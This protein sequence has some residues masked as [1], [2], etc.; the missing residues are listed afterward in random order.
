MGSAGFHGVSAHLLW[1]VRGETGNHPWRR[2]FHDTH[3]ETVRQLWSIV[4][5]LYSRVSSCSSGRKNFKSHFPYVPSSFHHIFSPYS[6]E[7]SLFLQQ[8]PNGTG[9]DAGTRHV[10]YNTRSVK[11]DLTNCM[12]Q[13]ESNAFNQ[14]C[15]CCT[16]LD[17]VYPIHT[18]HVCDIS[19]TISTAVD[20]A[21]LYST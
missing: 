9:I 2:S 12:L 1:R 11:Q 19:V 16:V 5:D 20:F 3:Y 7:N 14:P 13:E 8:K 18:S 10:F 17:S 4:Y 21:L 6:R 15:S